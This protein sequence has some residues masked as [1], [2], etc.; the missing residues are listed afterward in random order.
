MARARGRSNGS[1]A[2]V[3]DA[4]PSIST[5]QPSANGNHEASPD[6][7]SSRDTFNYRS[8]TLAATDALPYYDRELELQPGLRSR[9]DALIASEQATLPLLDE[10]R[11]PP[12]YKPFSNRPDLAAEL[13]RVASGAPPSP[14]LDT[15]RYTLPS[16][17]EGE[18]A[19]LELWQAA[20]DSAHA[21]LG[22]M[23]VRLKNIELL[24]KYGSNHWRLS[25]FQQEQD[26]RLLS[27]QV[28]AVKSE[29]NEINRLR[30][31]DQTAA[32]TK[33]GILEKRW[34]D[35]ISRGLQLEVARITTESE[36]EGL[37]TK[38]RK[39]EGQLAQMQ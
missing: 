16:P 14:A 26:I 19:S 27:E 32:G 28:E 20:V 18:S 33:L 13:E 36:I 30:Q 22:H 10:S 12:A 34:T 9:V 35:L 11:L 29:T 3:N 6:A 8:V 24:K 1:T 23:D 7:G 21:Q 4:V 31:K 17:P 25:N 15:S 38:K 2:S 5:I 39:L 37:R